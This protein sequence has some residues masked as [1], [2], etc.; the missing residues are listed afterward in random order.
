VGYPEDPHSWKGRT[1]NQ[2]VKNLALI[3]ARVSR[4]A[5]RASKIMISQAQ[6]V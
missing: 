5:P 6:Y 4:D 3:M 1:V 2:I